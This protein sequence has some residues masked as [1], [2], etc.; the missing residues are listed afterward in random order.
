MPI[1]KTEIGDPLIPVNKQIDRLCHCQGMDKNKL[2]RDVLKVT[3]I[4]L[5]ALAVLY[6]AFFA[7]AHRAPIDP[8]GHLFTADGT[9][10]TPSNR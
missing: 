8:V 1:K 4:K 2:V 7:P 5:S 3:L 6:F 10:P 9:P